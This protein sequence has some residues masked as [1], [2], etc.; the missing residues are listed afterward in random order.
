MLKLNQSS[1]GKTAA[2]QLVNLLS[3]DVQRFDLAAPFL[4]F[5]WIMPIQ[6]VI[7]L[8]LMYRSVGLAAFA[9]ISVSIIQAIPLQGK[10]FL[11]IC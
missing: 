3:N 2:G 6:S 1:L 5:F 11:D 10:T 8:Y 9:G 4:H 7:A